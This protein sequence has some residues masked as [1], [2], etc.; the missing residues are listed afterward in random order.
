[1]KI[2]LCFIMIGMS[3]IV[4]AQTSSP[5]WLHDVYRKINYPPEQWHTGFVQ[6]RLKPDADAGSVLKTIEREA[7]T[8][9]AESIFMTIESE[10]QSAN[11]G[12]NDETGATSPLK[13]SIKTF[14]SATLINLESNSYYDPET[15]MLYAFA[16]IK[17]SDVSKY[18]QNRLTTDLASLETAIEVIKQ[19]ITAREKRNAN[20]KI[21]EAQA[22][23]ADVRLSRTLLNAGSAGSASS[24]DARLQTGRED[25]LHHAL[26]QLLSGFNGNLMVYVNC[27]SEQK[28]QRHD[29][30]KENQDIFCNIIAQ[31]LNENNCL[32]TDDVHQADF[33]LKIITSTTQRSDG[34]DPY[35]IISYYANAKGTLYDL[36]AGRQLVDFY[37]VNDPQVYAAGRTPEDAAIK[38]FKLPALK[39]MVMEKILPAIIY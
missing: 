20:L 18:Y 3:M 37:V 33:E 23:L 10:T 15:G 5:I 12:E 27:Q 17:R 31:A 21:K 36:V 9:L 8:Q 7:I 32:I 1:M 11:T 14:T 29:A 39:E 28:G 2:F 35:G 26:E 34:A 25:E 22:L 30:L 6:D 19:H 38:A 13:Q 16:A 4:C 24:D